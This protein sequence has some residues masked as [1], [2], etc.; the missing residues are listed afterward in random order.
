[1]P[2]L[3]PNQQRRS[4]EGMKTM[5]I[6][7]SLKQHS[8]KILSK[9]HF[10]NL[11]YYGT[12]ITY[13]TILVIWNKIHGIMK[14]SCKSMAGRVGEFKVNFWSNLLTDYKKLKDF[15]NIFYQWPDKHDVLIINSANYYGF[16][17]AADVCWTLMATPKCCDKL[18]Y[19]VCLFWP[20][21]P[22]CFFILSL[23]NTHLI[24]L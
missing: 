4:T 23:P 1:M 20:L 12:N 8:K 21:R 17:S 14:I 7:I 10:S 15:S 6:T 2:F 3:P 19:I 24:F 5:I 22:S 9:F 18:E 16:D 11:I 13:K